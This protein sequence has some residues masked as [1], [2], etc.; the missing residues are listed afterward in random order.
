MFPFLGADSI[1]HAFDLRDSFDIPQGVIVFSAM[2]NAWL[3]LDYRAG[4]S[5]SVLYGDADYST[6]ETIAAS[7][8]E[9][10][11]NLVEG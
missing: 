9:F 8:D 10:L 1:I 11:G 7:F 6:M 2:G 4:V 5:P 3:G